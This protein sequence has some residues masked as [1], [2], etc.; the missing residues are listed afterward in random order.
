MPSLDKTGPQGSGQ[1]GRGFGPCGNH[2]YHGPAQQHRQGMGRRQ[3]RRH[4]CGTAD[5]HREQIYDYTA[6]ELNNRKQAL[7]KELQWLDDRIKEMGEQNENCP[8][9]N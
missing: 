2:P 8:A 6:E 1:P 3:R 7:Q 4:I 5:T 9:G